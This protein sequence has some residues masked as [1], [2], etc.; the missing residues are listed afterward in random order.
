MSSDNAGI[1]GG[2]LLRANMSP[3]HRILSFPP[4]TT[5]VRVRN[6]RVIDGSLYAL[7]EGLPA[8]YINC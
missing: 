7:A 4:P 8:N 1:N 6:S 2:F 3:A 5:L